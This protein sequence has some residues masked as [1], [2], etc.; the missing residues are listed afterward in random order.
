VVRVVERSST[1]HPLLI[2]DLLEARISFMG[3][4]LSSHILSGDDKAQTDLAE[5][6][7]LEAARLLGWVLFVQKNKGQ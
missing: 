3:M 6:I 4:I 2:R 7:A 1:T 5:D